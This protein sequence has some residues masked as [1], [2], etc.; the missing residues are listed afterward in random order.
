MLNNNKHLDIEKLTEVVLSTPPEIFLPENFADF[1]TK[2]AARRFAL[3]EYINEFLIYAAV[4]VGLIATSGS[5]SIFLVGIQLG[6][7]VSICVLKHYSC[8]RNDIFIVVYIIC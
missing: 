7:I 6:Q 4:I 3:E 5:Y 2:K 1:V 8:D